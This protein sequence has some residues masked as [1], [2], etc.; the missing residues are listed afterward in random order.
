MVVILVVS[1]DNF[2]SGERLLLQFFHDFRGSH[3]I[4]DNRC[5]HDHGQEQSQ[6]IPAPFENRL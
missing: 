1:K 4:I 6:G 3:T 5:R 2:Q